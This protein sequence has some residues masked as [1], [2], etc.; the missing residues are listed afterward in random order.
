MSINLTDKFIDDIY[1]LSHAVFPDAVIHQ[2]KRCLLDHLGATLAGAR[3]MQAKGEKLLDFMGGS[4]RDASV[5][6]FNRKIGVENAAFING[7]SS[8]IAELDDGV[9]SGIVHPGSPV[10]SALL[11][12]AEKEQVSGKA[13]LKGIIIGVLRPGV[14][15]PLHPP[16]LPFEV[17]FI[18][19]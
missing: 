18:I 2:A 4:S 17:K 14:P 5:I 3:L 16:D 19:L 10:L 8:H 12:V 1:E 9:I 15:A 11:P 6:G 13:L 7:L